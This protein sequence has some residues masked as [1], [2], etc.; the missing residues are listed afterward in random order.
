MTGRKFSE[1]YEHLD[2][3]TKERYKEKL[4]YIG[5]EVDDPFIFCLFLL[6]LVLSFCQMWN[7]QTSIIISLTHPVL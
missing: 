6:F 7:I 5:P 1:Y 3:Y 4:N 2:K